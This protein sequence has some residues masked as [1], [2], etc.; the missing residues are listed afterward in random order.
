M[1][2]PKDS[3]QFHCGEHVNTPYIAIGDIAVDLVNAVRIA[4]NP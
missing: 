2:L 3:S 4:G 1:N